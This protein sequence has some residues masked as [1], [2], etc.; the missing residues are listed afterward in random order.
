GFV[1]PVVGFNATSSSQNPPCTPTV[2]AGTVFVHPANP[3]MV[4]VG[5]KSPT[6]GSVTITGGVA[7]DD[8]TC[9]DGIRWYVDQANT[10]L[11]EGATPRG[12]SASF[13]TGL[14]ATVQIGTYLYFIV[15]AG[16]NGNISCDTTRL[17]VSIVQATPTSISLLS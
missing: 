16:A 8:A 1:L 2:P 3:Q 9:G 14:Q 11:A 7:S 5:W 17:D 10:T 6:S 12:G 13:P 15:D 4:I